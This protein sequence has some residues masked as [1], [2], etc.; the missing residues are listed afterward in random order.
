MGGL[1][2]VIAF[3]CALLALV[4]IIV[5]AD[6]R[7]VFIVLMFLSLAHVLGGSIEVPWRVTRG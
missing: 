3:L 4:G 5:P 7:G 6:M 2:A 1:F